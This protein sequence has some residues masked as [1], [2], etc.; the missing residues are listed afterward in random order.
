MDKC[1]TKEGKKI[2]GNI[3]AVK[4]LIGYKYPDTFY[5]VEMDRFSQYKFDF[6]RTIETYPFISSDHPVVI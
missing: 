1:L 5:Q 2:V 4:A 3:F 6:A